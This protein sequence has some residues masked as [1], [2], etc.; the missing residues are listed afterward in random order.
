MVEHVGYRPDLELGRAVCWL[1]RTP[2][3]REVLRRYATEHPNPGAGEWVVMRDDQPDLDSGAI[4][5]VR[6]S[7]LDA[8]EALV[9]ERPDLLPEFLP[10]IRRATDDPSPIVRV[11]A[12]GSCLPVL[13]TDRD[14]A[15]EL[16][17]RAC[18]TDDRALAT[19]NVNHFLSYTLATHQERMEPLL[20]RMAASAENAVAERGAVWLAVNWIHDR[21]S[22]PALDSCRCGTPAQRRG[23]AAAAAH[24][25]TDRR[26]TAGCAELLLDLI[27]DPDESVQEALAEF[28]RDPKALDSPEVVA[29]ARRFAAG[30]GL[31]RQPIWL[32]EALLR[33]EDSLVRVAD[34][35]FT[36]SERLTGDLAAAARTRRAD[37]RTSSTG[38]FRSCSGSTSRRNRS[39]TWNS[40][41]GASTGGTDSSRLEF[42]ASVRRPASSTAPHDARLVER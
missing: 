33:R 35:V 10:T 23:V 36:V 17:L 5:C 26:L 15:V 38:S 6:G 24:N 37:T 7:V 13:N 28:L 30:P 1:V 21:V 34:L 42:G 29:V 9:F 11:A 14:L 22:R 39:G 18:E 40:A 2:P 41:A 31:A 12:V 32:V 3:C 20:A 8:I 27:D 4:N 25:I 16:F 19:H